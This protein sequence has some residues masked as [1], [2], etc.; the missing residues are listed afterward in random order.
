MLK[1]C[2]NTR[3]VVVA[4]PQTIK[5]SNYQVQIK[6]LD[7]NAKT[8]YLL[9]PTT[10]V[11]SPGHINYTVKTYWKGVRNY[12]DSVDSKVVTKDDSNNKNR[13][14]IEGKKLHRQRY[15]KVATKDS[16]NKK[17]WYIVVKSGYVPA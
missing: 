7:D 13:L 11:M 15:C 6:F 2:E 9:I 8:F 10:F 3:R 1:V 17:R 14:Y 5:N 16:T 4:A 12:T